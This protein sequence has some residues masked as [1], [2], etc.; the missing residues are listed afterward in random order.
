MPQSCWNM[1][2]SVSHPSDQ[3]FYTEDPLQNTSSSSKTQSR[4]KTLR[5]GYQKLQVVA[6]NE[7]YFD[8]EQNRRRWACWWCNWICARVVE[9]EEPHSQSLRDE[10]QP[11]LR[12]QLGTL[13]IYCQCSRSHYGSRRC[14]HDYS[15]STMHVHVHVY[16]HLLVL[17][18]K[19]AQEQILCFLVLVWCLVLR[20]QRYKRMSALT[21]KQPIHWFIPFKITSSRFLA[22]AIIYRLAE[23]RGFLFIIDTMATNK[24]LVRKYVRVT[25][26]YACIH[27]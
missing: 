7:T 13:S 1:P 15:W 20:V 21:W 5:A 11:C 14:L 9:T 2:L 27:D 8:R 24:W 3:T 19:L 12:W 22:A 18:L 26:M 17:P 16:C 25:W 4:S 10:N 6:P 23:R